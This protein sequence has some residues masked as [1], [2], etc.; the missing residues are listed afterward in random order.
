MYIVPAD[1]NFLS[2]PLD[3]EDIVELKIDGYYIFVASNTIDENQ[4]SSNVVS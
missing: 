1:R 2:S 4:Y 3:D